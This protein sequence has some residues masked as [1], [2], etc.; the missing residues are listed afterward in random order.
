[1]FGIEDKK[2]QD[3]RVPLPA[4]MPEGV[5]ISPDTYRANRIPPGQTRTVKF[6]VLDAFGPPRINAAD[7]KLVIA[8]LVHVPCRAKPT[9]DLGTPCHALARRSMTRLARRATAA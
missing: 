4:D 2:T 3:A 8:G 1:M 9:S 7:W 6:P 5:I